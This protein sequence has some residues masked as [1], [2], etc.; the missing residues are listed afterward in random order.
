MNINKKCT[1]LWLN[2]SGKTQDNKLDIG[3]EIREVF[4]SS[5]ISKSKSKCACGDCS[6]CFIK[7]GEYNRYTLSLKNVKKYQEIINYRS[8]NQTF[9]NHIYDILESRYGKQNLF[10][11]GRNIIIKGDKRIPI[12]DL[13][14]NFTRSAKSSGYIFRPSGIITDKIDKFAC[15]FNYK[16]RDRFLNWIN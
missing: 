3:L 9:F 4:G 13:I 5:N 15:L 7:D 11:S 10:F 8:V 1:M 14:I 16:E 6:T 2:F 12:R